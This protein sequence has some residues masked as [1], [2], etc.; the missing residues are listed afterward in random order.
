MKTTEQLKQAAALY[1]VDVIKKSCAAPLVLGV[2]TGSTVNYFIEALPSMRGCIDVTVAS[3]VATHDLLKKHRIPVVDLNSVDGVDVYVDGADQINRFLQMLK[4][5]GGALTREKIIAATAKKFIC[6]ADEHKWVA[7][8]GVG[9]PV[10][11]EVIPMARSFVARQILKLGGQPVFR[12]GFVT[13]NGQHIIDVHFPVVNE[14]IT[15][16]Q[17][18]NNIPGVVAHGL[19]ALRPADQLIRAGQECVEVVSADGHA[20]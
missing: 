15:L 13:D 3:S 12:E 9:F 5:G 17:Q 2:G 1:A 18:L 19:F 8:L 10:V 14:P 4:G 7:A 6:I 11:I 20:Y 16:E